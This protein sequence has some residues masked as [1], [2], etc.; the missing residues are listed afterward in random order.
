MIGERMSWEEIIKKYPNKWIEMDHIRETENGGIIDA[1][2]V[3]IDDVK[4]MEKKLR[5][6][7]GTTL[8]LYTTPEDGRLHLWGGF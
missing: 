8:Y 3:S 7:T 6:F 4:D 2:I 5:S 1:E